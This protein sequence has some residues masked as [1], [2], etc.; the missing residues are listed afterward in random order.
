MCCSD[1]NKNDVDMLVMENA[2]KQEWT[3][4]T[5]VAMLQDLPS[6]VDFAGVT[7]PGGEIVLVHKT[8]YSGLA[9]VVYY[10][11]PKRNSRRRA[12][13]QTTTSLFTRNPSVYVRIRAVTDHVENIMRL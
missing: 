5:F 12:E 10:Y 2:E 1:L 3:K 11:D 6:R 9:S 7:H 8:Y 13:I 4:I